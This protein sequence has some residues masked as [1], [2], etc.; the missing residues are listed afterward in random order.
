MTRCSW[1]LRQGLPVADILYVTPEGAPEVFTPPASA[2]VYNSEFPDRREYNFDGCSPENLMKN[3]TVH[4]GRIVFPD[5]MS[6]RVAVL[7]E[8]NTMTPDLLRKVI[9]LVR[10]GAVVQGT[11]P[12]KSPSLVGYPK[13]DDEVRDLT[14]TLWGDA[15]YQ[16]ERKLGL[17]R[18]VYAGLST[19]LSV[20]DS[21][22]IWYDEG[23]PQN[24][25][26]AGR[27]W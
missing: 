18:V 8:W 17:G 5:G 16:H 24:S 19:G 20:D 6:Y 3:A 22:W 7:P 13:C 1:L 26:P 12:V 10:A 4:N 15:P 9:V 23:E 25:A 2:L 11:P 14:A 27:R 21:S